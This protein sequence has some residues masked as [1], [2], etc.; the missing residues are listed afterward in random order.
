[1]TSTEVFERLVDLRMAIRVSKR[2]WNDP[3]S[4]LYRDEGLKRIIKVYKNESNTLEELHYNQETEDFDH[5]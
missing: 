5:E 3:F 4:T 2:L 1:M